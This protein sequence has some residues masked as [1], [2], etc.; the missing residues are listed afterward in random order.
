VP[1]PHAD[2]ALLDSLIS[3]HQPVGRRGRG[4]SHIPPGAEPA[5]PSLEQTA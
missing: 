2:A 3:A 1:K 4:L 5:Q